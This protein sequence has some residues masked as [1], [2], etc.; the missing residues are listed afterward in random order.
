M[1]PRA[2]ERMG[3]DALTALPVPM[4]DGVSIDQSFFPQSLSSR[5]GPVDRPRHWYLR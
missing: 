1:I 5:I 2:C 3:Q 4:R